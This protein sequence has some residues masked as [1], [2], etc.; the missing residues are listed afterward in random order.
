MA[1]TEDLRRRYT[2]E[3]ELGV[4]EAAQQHITRRVVR[5]PPASAAR[6][7]FERRRP[8]FLR[9]MAAEATGVFFYVLPGVAATASQTFAIINAA[10]SAAAPPAA[11]LGSLLN[12]AVAFGFGIAFAI[13][14]SA[15]TSGGHFNPA[16]TVAFVLFQGFPIKKAMRYIVAQ[17]FGAFLAGL[18]IYGIWHQQFAA[19]LAGGVEKS[20]LIGI[21]CAYPL[22]D[23]TIGYLFLVEFFVDA[24]LGMVIWSVLDPANPFIAPASAPWAIGLA[25]TAMVIGFA[26]ITISTNLAR[27]LGTR[28][29]AAAFLSTDAFTYKSYSWIGIL[30]NVPATLFSVAYYEFVMKDTM[31]HIAEG[32]LSHPDEHEAKHYNETPGDVSPNPTIHRHRSGERHM[33]ETEEEI[34]AFGGTR[35]GRFLSNRHHSGG[36]GKLEQPEF[37]EHV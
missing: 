10:E 20:T 2:G 21:L 33:S 6:L 12:V 18:L 4:T 32:H 9:E 23:Q 5:P 19:A 16:I 7:A 30:V 1:E 37:R 14:T 36:S 26:S 34:G 8:K 15:S 28:M 35:L 11:V 3:M 22:P 24:F 13:I 25:Y 27:D 31:T 29:V 17:I